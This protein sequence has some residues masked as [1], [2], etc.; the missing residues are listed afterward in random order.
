MDSCGTS[1]SKT[2]THYRNSATMTSRRSSSPQSGRRRASSFGCGLVIPFLAVGPAWA[3]PPE[4]PRHLGSP[5][6]RRA[7]MDVAV[8]ASVAVLMDAA[9]GQVLY[10]RNAHLA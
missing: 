8:T 5:P 7:A 6:H 1:D 2:S 4:P 3:A 9:T 10:E